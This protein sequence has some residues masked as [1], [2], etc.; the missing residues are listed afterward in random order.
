MENLYI[1]ERVYLKL[2]S[3]HE[4]DERYLSWFKSEGLVQYY[5]STKREFTRDYLVQ[6]LRAGGSIPPLATFLPRSEL[7]RAI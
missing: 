2:L 5:S 3:E 1:G 7:V 4:I 6:D